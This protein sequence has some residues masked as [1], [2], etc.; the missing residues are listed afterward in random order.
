MINEN[1][2]CLNDIKIYSKE[3][4][5]YI[6]YN[7]FMTYELKEILA[8]FKSSIK[9]IDNIN[10]YILELQSKISDLEQLID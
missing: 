4:L 1:V 10:H 6:Q 9:E 5:E 2:I 7:F 3:L 8:Y